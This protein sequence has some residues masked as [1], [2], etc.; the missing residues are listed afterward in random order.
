MYTTTRVYTGCHFYVH[1]SSLDNNASTT[2][3]LTYQTGASLVSL[4]CPVQAIWLH[5]FGPRDLR[6]PHYIIVW[7]IYT[8]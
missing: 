1:I 7:Q 6:G 5:N 4:F 3:A 2:R 8:V